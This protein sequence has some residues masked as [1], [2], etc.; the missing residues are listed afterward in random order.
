MKKFSI[1]FLLLIT[2]A[3]AQDCQREVGGGACIVLEND[4]YGIKKKGKYIIPAE[5]EQI[6]DHSGLY[7]SVE[8]GGKWGLYDIKGNMILPAAYDKIMMVDAAAGLIVAE[9]KGYKN[10]VITDKISRA[11]A[12]SKDNPFLVMSTWEVTVSEYLTFLE[13]TKKNAGAGISFSAAMP[14]T[15]HMGA[16]GRRIFS[17]YFS[18]A[19]KGNCQKKLEVFKGVSSID[20]LMVNCELLKDKKLADYMNLPVTGI[21]Y[22]QAENYFNW[23]TVKFNQ[24]YTVD[25][26]YEMKIRMPKPAEWENFAR[27]GFVD[28]QNKGARDSV[29]V[30]K[31]LLFNYKFKE[32]NC[33]QV[34][35]Q[36]DMYGHNETKAVSYM[37]DMNGLYNL[38]G[39][40]AEM[41]T[42]KGVAKGGSYQHY[43]R[44]ANVT[45]QQNY[46]GAQPWLGVRWVAEYKLK[47]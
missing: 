20:P 25:E 37:P 7:F 13:D 19:G 47:K 8:K 30:K 18:T 3:K 34:K 35:E 39:N 43:A 32:E 12:V 17:S 41:T 10:V 23:L 26:R 46:E 22:E 4:M 29:N 27:S 11:G 6:A 16:N 1:L 33:E 31:C 38:F 9:G 24:Q 2:V 42:E 14:D 5:Y 40:A 44:Q 28:E 36:L 21:T 45:Q 15:S